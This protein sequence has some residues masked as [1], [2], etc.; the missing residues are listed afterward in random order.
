M[1]REPASPVVRV[2]GW[3]AVV[4]SVVVAFHFLAVVV[5]IMATPNGPWPGEEG[6]MMGDPPAFAYNLYRNIAFPYLQLLKF[7]YHFN[8][9]GNRPGQEDIAFQ[10]R[11]R[12]AQR[13]EIA[14]LSFP[15]ENVNP[16]VKHRQELLARCLGNDEPVMP[17]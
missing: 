7:N 17:G 2:P 8:F 11:L 12:D 16:W 1:V 4:F 6:S 14:V 5:C 10:V 15:E 3:V 13:Q 9:A